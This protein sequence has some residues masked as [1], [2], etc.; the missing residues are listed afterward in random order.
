[1][2]YDEEMAQTNPLEYHARKQPNLAPWDLMR[3]YGPENISAENLFE[4]YP[5]WPDTTIPTGE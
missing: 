5:N 4:H 2:P 1:M 3:Q